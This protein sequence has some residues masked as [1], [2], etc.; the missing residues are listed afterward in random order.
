MSFGDRLKIKEVVLGDRVKDII[1]KKD[2]VK[3]AKQLNIDARQVRT[4]WEDYKM[5]QCG[6]RTGQL[7]GML[8]D[9]P[10]I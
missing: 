8:K 3:F 5:R 2:I 10:K 9:L 1:R 4:G 7:R 6:T